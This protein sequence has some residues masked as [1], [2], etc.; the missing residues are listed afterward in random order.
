[1]KEKDLKNL[2]SLA[3]PYADLRL[4]KDSDENLKVFDP[5]RKK[6]V[7]LTPEEF[8]RQNFIH[9]LTGHLGYPLSLMGNEVEI[10]LNDTKKRC[11]TV[12]YDKKGN[13][14]MI[15]EY[16]APNVEI[17]Q[18][19]FDQ[20]VRYNME[21]KAKYL[22]VSNGRNNY[23]CVIDYINGTYNFIRLIPDY[24]QAVGQP[25]VN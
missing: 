15:I 6:F 9:W 5:T 18:D 21:L 24:M 14:L 10:C 13:P 22:V 1:M 25:G 11:D 12:V 8:V 3:I 19:T 20:V 23:C 17:T 4:A 2:P 7:N 16:K